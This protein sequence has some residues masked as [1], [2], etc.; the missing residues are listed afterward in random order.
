MQD[1][2]PIV[3]H[4]VGDDMRQAPLQQFPGALLT[5]L[6]STLGKLLKRADGTGWRLGYSVSIS[7]DTVVVGAP[8][9]RSSDKGAA[10]VYLKP[11]KGWKNSTETARLGGRQKLEQLGLSV[12]ATNDG[13]QVAAGAPGMGSG[14]HIAVRPAARWLDDDVDV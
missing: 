9:W 4:A 3:F 12:S 10:Y 13:H 8:R 5:P 11:G 2:N 14:G 1:F 6:A 7:A